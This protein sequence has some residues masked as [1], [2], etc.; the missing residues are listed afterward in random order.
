[1][2]NE[3]LA[4]DY[5]TYIKAEY[6]NTGFWSL[7]SFRNQRERI[8]NTSENIAEY[9]MGH[10]NLRQLKADGIGISTKKTLEKILAKGLI[11][12]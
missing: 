1:M 10:G 6:P 7:I 9:Y 12:S 4:Q 2:D 8:R 11:F 3:K 5:W